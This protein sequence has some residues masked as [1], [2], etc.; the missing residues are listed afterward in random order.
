M[1]VLKRV[2]LPSNF[3]VNVLNLN[4]VKGGRINDLL[5]RVLNPFNVANRLQFRSAVDIGG[6]AETV[7]LTNPIAVSPDGKLTAFAHKNQIHLFSQVGSYILEQAHQV[8][9]L[10]FVAGKVL[11]TGNDDGDVEVFILTVKEPIFEAKCV[12]KFSCGRD[13]GIF[14]IL[15]ASDEHESTFQVVLSRGKCMLVFDTIAC[16]SGNTDESTVAPAIVDLLQQ[17]PV[18]DGDCMSGLLAT[19]ALN[20]VFVTNT[21][22]HKAISFNIESPTRCLWASD[23]G[24]LF[25][26]TQAGEVLDCAWSD[27]LIGVSTF[28][29][30]IN[31]KPASIENTGLVVDPELVD[32]GQNKL[33]TISNGDLFVYQRKQ[34]GNERQ[35]PVSPISSEFL[36]DKQLPIR[37]NPGEEVAALCLCDMNTVCVIATSGGNSFRA[38]HATI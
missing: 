29:K 21:A 16:I 8:T 22:S 2:E 33:V 18:T 27:G 36:L 20:S 11:V 19:I 1:T 30:A 17:Q 7:S 32:I 15:I 38:V 4:K 37:I 25:I 12:Y 14:P 9:C 23:I 26:V 28:P 5:S 31:S 10:G 35:Y 34:A 13:S 6:L 3:G 24:H